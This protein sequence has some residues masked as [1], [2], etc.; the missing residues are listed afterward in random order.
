M[1]YKK[2]PEYKRIGIALVL[3]F[4]TFTLLT[5]CSSSSSAKQGT[6]LVGFDAKLTQ[7]A[8]DTDEKHLEADTTTNHLDATNDELNI[9]PN[10]K[11]TQKAK[12]C[13]NELEER[14]LASGTPI[15]SVSMRVPSEE[16]AQVVREYTKKTDELPVVVVRVPLASL[17]DVTSSTYEQISR[18]AIA[19]VTDGSPICYLCTV[20]VEESTGEEFTWQLELI[21][22]RAH[23]SEW[24]KPAGLDYSQAEADIKARVEKNCKEEKLTLNSFNFSEDNIGRIVEIRANFLDASTKTGNYLDALRLYFVKLNNED[25]AKISLVKIYIGD[26]NG[27]LVADVSYDFASASDSMWLD[28]QYRDDNA[29]YPEVFGKDDDTHSPA[30]DGVYDMEKGVIIPAE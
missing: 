15:I 2:S 12:K 29:M 25:G 20:G 13:L 22:D 24:Q 4:S 28:P 27:K 16:E 17:K 18:Q 6:A 21:G 3:L 1:K 7:H 26:E 5:G 14:L 19:L 23:A 11:L 9:I 10:N 30:K 8:S